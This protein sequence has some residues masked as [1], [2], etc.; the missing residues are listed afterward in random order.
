MSDLENKIQEEIF[1]KCFYN[2]REKKEKKVVYWFLI[3]FELV[4]ELYDRILNIIVVQKKYRDLDY[5]VK[6]LVKELKINICYFLVVVNFCFG[7]NYF[8]LLNE[9]RVKDVLYLLM[10]KR[11]V[12]KNVEEISVMV[13]FVNCQFFYVVFYKNV[14]EIFNGYCKKYVEKKK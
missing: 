5:L 10:D 2:L 14:G 4:D 6:D 1:K 12:D 3:R 13:G 8:C 11:Y 9:Y 7:M